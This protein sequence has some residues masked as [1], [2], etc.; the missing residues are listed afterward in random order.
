MRTSA[1]YCGIREQYLLQPLACLFVV[2]SRAGGSTNGAQAKTQTIANYN[3]ATTLRVFS[4]VAIHGQFCAE[5]A[6]FFLTW[7]RKP[8]GLW[9]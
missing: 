8:W 3:K 2:V 1:A 5:S 9:H 7:G 6:A 4:C